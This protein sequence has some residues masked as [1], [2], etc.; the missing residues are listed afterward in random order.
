VSA[1]GR[2]R[3]IAGWQWPAG[4]P[5]VQFPN[6]PLGVALLASATAAVTHGDA[7]R[8]AR[9]LFYLALGVW[10]YEEAWHGE[11]WFRRLLGAGFSVYLVIDL[12]RSLHA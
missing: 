3:R 10:A 9:A 2:L 12:A 6:P 8:A 1:T 7:H 11:N 5:L 4:F